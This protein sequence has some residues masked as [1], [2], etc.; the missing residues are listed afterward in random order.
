MVIDKINEITDRIENI[1]GEEV[2]VLDQS[3]YEGMNKL[4]ERAKYEKDSYVLTMLVRDI[5]FICK[6]LSFAIAF[7]KVP[8]KNSFVDW[9]PC[10]IYKHDGKW[11]RV[12]LEHA[13]CLR[14][15]WEGRIANPTNPDLYFNL[16][17]EFEVLHDMYKLPFCVCPKCGGEISRKAIWIEDAE[18][19]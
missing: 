12:Q 4:A 5:K 1:D 17:K 15:D 10:L 19:E 14:C 11:R 13:N 6:N 16:K 8:I 3:M 9:V 18:K 7:R 2:Y